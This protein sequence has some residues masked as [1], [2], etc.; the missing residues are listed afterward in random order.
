MQKGVFFSL[1]TCPEDIMFTLVLAESF[2]D[3]LLPAAQNM[4]PHWM[5]SSLL[6][7]EGKTGYKHMA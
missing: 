6:L 7:D 5:I 2:R 4:H 3:M 1:G